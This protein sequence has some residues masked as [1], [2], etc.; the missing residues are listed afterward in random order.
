VHAR[1]LAPLSSK[2]STLESYFCNRSRRSIRDRYL[3]ESYYL[4]ESY[5]IEEEENI[6]SEGVIAGDIV[7]DLVRDAVDIVEEEDV[8]EGVILATADL[9]QYPNGNCE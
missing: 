1:D 5:S 2:I 9:I 8:A 4:V 3:A 7:D 6:D